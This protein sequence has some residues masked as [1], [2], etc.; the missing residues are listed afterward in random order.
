MDY[1]C[2]LPP[3]SH[4]SIFKFCADLYLS[5]FSGITEAI[6]QRRIFFSLN[7]GP[8][9]GGGGKSMRDL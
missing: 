7:L 8:C 3:T 9:G 5:S 6:N 4:I 2:T 1:T